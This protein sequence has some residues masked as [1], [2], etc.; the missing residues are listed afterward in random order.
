MGHVRG[1][2]MLTLDG[3]SYLQLLFYSV[4]RV[5]KAK[6]AGG[7]NKQMQQEATRF[8]ANIG[9]K[10]MGIDYKSFGDALHIP[11]RCHFRP[12][13]RPSGKTRYYAVRVGRETG[14]FPSWK[15][16]RRHVDGFSRPEYGSL[17]L[18]RKPRPSSPP[19]LWCLRV[20]FLA[21]A[22]HS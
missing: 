7:P 11:R 8:Q 18:A 22:I 17:K 3:G 20:L 2:G 1:A 21:P 5:K 6:S 12:R 4:R 19:L 10:S 13:S 15:D 16:A 9:Y 14:I